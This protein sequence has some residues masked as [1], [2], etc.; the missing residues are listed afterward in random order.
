MSI[1]LLKFSL[2]CL[3]IIMLVSCGKPPAMSSEDRINTS[4]AQTVVAAQPPE[5]HLPTPGVAAPGD[6]APAPT[7]QITLTPVPLPTLPPPAAS[8]TEDTCYRA[9]W[10]QDVTIPDGTRISPSA[11]FTKTWR[12]QNIG[13]C[14]WNTGYALVY[15]GGHSTGAP[16]S[17]ALPSNVPPGG[18]IDVSVIITAP[19]TNGD[20]I[21]KFKLRSDN[22]RVF[23]FGAGFAYPLTAEIKVEPVSLLP[24]IPTT[25]FEVVPFESLKYDFAAN[26]CSATWENW[27]VGLPCPGADNDSRGFVVRRDNPKLQD[28]ST[29]DGKSLFTHPEWVDGGMIIG[30]YPAVAIENGYRFRATIGCGYGGTNCDVLFRVNYIKGSDPLV[31]L[32][33]WSMKYSNAPLDIDIDLSSL[34]GSDVKFEFIVSANGSSSQDWA[35]W[36][37]PRIVLLTIT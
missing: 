20:Y 30:Y 26:Y 36:L 17:T 31:E 21:W 34:A 15:D 14:T 23:G 27:L 29:R 10:I 1:R 12:V 7:E 8:A 33:T 13:T 6:T 9:K 22:G 18:T 32:G 35:H 4:V 37:K 24:L 2:V 28:G 5:A 11:T 19:A 25:E 16:A 3:F